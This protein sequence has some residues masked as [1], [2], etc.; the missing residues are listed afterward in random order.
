MII[1]IGGIGCTGKTLMAQTLLE[2]YKIPYF[3]A[4]YLKM[5]LVRGTDNCPFTPMAA[6]RRTAHLCGPF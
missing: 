2:K 6:T 5:G 4:D 3:S 1:L